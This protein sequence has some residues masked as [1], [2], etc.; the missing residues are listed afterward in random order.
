MNRLL[1]Q[2]STSV[3][4]CHV[5]INP[6]RI[7]NRSFGVGVAIPGTVALV[8]V[9]HIVVAAIKRAQRHGRRRRIRRRAATSPTQRP[10]P[11]TICLLNIERQVNLF[12]NKLALL[13]LLARFIRP[14]VGPPHQSIATSAKDI[15]HAVQ[16]R[17]E[18]SILGGS[19][20]HIDTVIQEI[21]AAVAT[22]KALGNDI[23]LRRQVRAAL[24]AGVD[25]SGQVDHGIVEALGVEGFVVGD[26][27]TWNLVRESGWTG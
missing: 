23:V 16:T 5:L 3:C 15:T 19:D 14:L 8:L 25:L 13:V 17:H 11:P 12:H 18:T 20:G 24:G 10:F 6:N 27:F 22:V 2:T 26:T 4:V 1:M 7:S 21:S 9:D